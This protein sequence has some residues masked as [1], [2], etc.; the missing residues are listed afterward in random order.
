MKIKYLNKVQLYVAVLIIGTLF[1][2]GK[3]SS[4][5][6]NTGKKVS[7]LRDINLDV[8]DITLND[9]VNLILTQSNIVEMRVEGGE[10]LVPYIKTKIEGNTLKI[11]NDNKCNFLRSYDEPITVYL[12]MPNIHGINYTGNGNITSTNVFNLNEFIFDTRSGTGSINMLMNVD[13][14]E[15]RQHSGPADFTFIGSA[16]K[17]FIYTGGSGWFYFENFITED[18]HVNNDASGDVKIY[19]YQ[20]LLIELTSVGNIDYYGN[21]T[22]TIS[23]HSGSGEIRK[24]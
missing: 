9:N 7:E 2:C 20:S 10:N 22:L 1:S 19:A 15:V 24:K 14:L 3:D 4:C 8:T 13:N 17:V 11:T 21:P 5:L 18:A 6:K 12:S 23:S 16:K